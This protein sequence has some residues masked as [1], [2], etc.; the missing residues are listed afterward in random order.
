MFIDIKCLENELLASRLGYPGSS[1]QYILVELCNKIYF[2]RKQY[3]LVA[4][5]IYISCGTI[6][7]Y[8]ARIRRK[9][10]VSGK[11][12]VSLPTKDRVW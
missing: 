2:W 8:I 6:G 12:I 11:N 4:A 9:Y 1:R 3:K 5:I 10:L 7:H